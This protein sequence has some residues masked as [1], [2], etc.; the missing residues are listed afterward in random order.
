MRTRST[1]GLVAAFAAALCLAAASPL[2]AV[3]G[4]PS[5][6]TSHPAVGFVF[7][8]QSDPSVCNSEVIGCQ[9]VLIAPDVFLTSGYC[10]DV[11][12][13]ASEYGYSLTAVWV[14]FN[15]DDPLDCSSAIRVKEFHV[16]PNFDETATEPID[17]VGVMILDTPSAIT[18][19]GLPGLDENEALARRDGVI[20]VGYGG[21]KGDNIRAWIRRSGVAGVVGVDEQTVTSRFAL[22]GV[23]T[24][25]FDGQGTFVG[26]SNEISGITA[27]FGGPCRRTTTQRVDI[28]SVRDFL[29]DFVT[30]P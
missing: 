3:H 1:H 12:A 27:S 21:L 30:L 29:D 26:A 2:F 11:F 16:H 8:Q 6:G 13:D 17:D 23:C 14:T 4:G 25:V 20:V 7:G 22:H 10:A 18:P 5:D 9:G 28:Q 24:G 15:P 19:A